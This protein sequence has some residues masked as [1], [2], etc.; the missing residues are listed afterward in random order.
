MALY[1]RH[2]VAYHSER[3]TA[4]QDSLIHIAIFR[5]LRKLGKVSISV[6]AIQVSKGRELFSL[7]FK[8]I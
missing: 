4:S 1:G 3:K 6:F 2:A 5:A 8:L 7:Y